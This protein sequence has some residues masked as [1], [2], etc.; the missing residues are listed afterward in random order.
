MLKLLLNGRPAI[1]RILAKSSE[2]FIPS[3]NLPPITQNRIA[4]FLS[5]DYF[6]YSI[7]LEYFINTSSF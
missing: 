5:F 2:K 3:D 1:I 4:P 6:Y 7:Y